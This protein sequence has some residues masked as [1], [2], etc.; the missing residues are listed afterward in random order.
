[1]TRLPHFRAK[2]LTKPGVF[3][4]SHPAMMGFPNDAIMEISAESPSSLLDPIWRMFPSK[5]RIAHAVVVPGSMPTM[6]QVFNFKEGKGFKF[7]NVWNDYQIPQVHLV[8]LL[9]ACQ[10]E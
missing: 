9:D 8:P 4:L 2:S 1:M 10:G 5:S 7:L 3:C 6:R